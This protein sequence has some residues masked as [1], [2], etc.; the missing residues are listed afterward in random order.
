MRTQSELHR[1]YEEGEGNREKLLH[2]L[3]EGKHFYS[4]E[5]KCITAACAFHSG[6]RHT[7]IEVNVHSYRLHMAYRSAGSGLPKILGGLQNPS[8]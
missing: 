6:G 3:R 1:V 5:K 7:F 8:T 2:A 4:T